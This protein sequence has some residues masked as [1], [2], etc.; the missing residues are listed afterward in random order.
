MRSGYFFISQLCRKLDTKYVVKTIAPQRLSTAFMPMLLRS[1][2][3]VFQKPGWIYE[4]KL[5]G[6]RCIAVCNGADTR[7]YS[8]NGRDISSTF[9]TLCRSLAGQRAGLVLDGE[10]VAFDSAGKISFE[11]LQERWLIVDEQIA[12]KQDV[13]NP[14]AFYVFDI[15]R[16]DNADCTKETLVNRKSML[17][18]KVSADLLIKLVH[19][20]EDAHALFD[21]T[22]SGG[23]EGI[24][25]K[26]SNSL[27]KP[28]ARS[29]EWIKIKH[30][31]T[32]S[33]VVLGYVE[34]E[35]FLLGQY[36]LTGLRTVGIARYG[37]SNSEYEKLAKRLVQIPPPVRFRKATVWFEPKVSVE[38]EFMEWTSKGMLRFPVLRRVT[39]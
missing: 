30:R 33:F 38:V 9:P 5:D 6:M 31:L 37:L 34:S 15:M 17:F 16:T 7:I 4:P 12:R 26:Q 18:E 24:V 10:I 21:A 32:E 13:H 3:E 14:V 29:G 2:R 35:G 20:F 19:H 23:L 28:G 11:N 25:A 27:Y 39:E 22:K 8:R 1:Q 36:T